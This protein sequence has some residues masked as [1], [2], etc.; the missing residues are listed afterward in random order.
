MAGRFADPDAGSVLGTVFEPDGAVAQFMA[1]REAKR[2]KDFAQAAPTDAVGLR[3]RLFDHAKKVANG[4]AALDWDD[5][6]QFITEAQKKNPKL[7]EHVPGLVS[8]YAE[9]LRRLAA[10]AGAPGMAGAAEHP[11]IMAG[12][13]G[14]QSMPPGAPMA[15]H[16]IPGMSSITRMTGA[17]MPQSMP[18]GAPMAGHG[19]PGM[20]SITRMTGAEMPQMSTPDMAPRPGGNEI[21]DYARSIAG[22]PPQEQFTL[23]PGQVR[24][25]G[26]K[27][28]AAVPA[29]EEPAGI[30]NIPEG[31]IGVTPE[32]GIIQNPKA[33]ESN[34]PIDLGANQQAAPSLNAGLE[35]AARGDFGTLND[36]IRF[37]GG[38]K[39]RKFWKEVVTDS[40]IY[41]R[42]IE[43]AGLSGLSNQSATAINKALNDGDS[44]A[45]VAALVAEGSILRKQETSGGRG[46]NIN[47]NEVEFKTQPKGS[48]MAD[49]VNSLSSFAWGEYSDKKGD[50]VKKIVEET[51]KLRNARLRAHESNL[52]GLVKHSLPAA[53][54]QQLTPEQYDMMAK[55]LVRKMPLTGKNGGGG[56]RPAGGGAAV[57]PRAGFAS[58]ENA[59]ADEA[60]NG[61][62]DAI[63][64]Q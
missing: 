24:Y 44:K 2:Q 7:K 20:S 58:P 57:P 15:G 29:E 11:A 52:V 40:P 61:A 48:F 1:A 5:V 14:P 23:G 46:E 47:M 9:E 37:A 64:G 4:Q 45:L 36:A 55:A 13:D 42:V 41:K 50:V 38:D 59:A 53:I 6:S 3:Q 56:G 39:F 28:I 54:S 60:V 43:Q 16:G 27:P 26:G 32:G 31:A 12:A 22:A 51:R 8:S 21:L 19:I 10:G 34:Y 18:P 63:M 30:H 62:V 33:P 35:A 25:E 17:E 49:L